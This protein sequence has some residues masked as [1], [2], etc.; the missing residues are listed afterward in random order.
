MDR[1]IV[2][3][4]SLP[5]D[6]D[7]LLPQRFT[8]IAVGMLMRAVMGTGTVI[9][10]LAVTQQASPNMTVQIGQGSLITQTVIDPTGVAFGSLDLDGSTNLVKIATNVAPVNMTA[11]TAPVTSGQSQNW[12]IEAQFLEVDGS[13]TVLP[14][15]NAANPSI[16][17]TGPANAG[18]SQNTLRTNR[19][20]FQWK[21]GAAAATGQ[22][23]TPTPD[24]GWVGIALV[25]VTNGQ[26]SILNSHITGYSAAPYVPTKMPQLRRQ[27][28]QD[29]SIFVSTFG[30]DTNNSGLSASSPFLTLQKAWNY[31]L[32]SLDLN[33]Y[34]V[35]VFV[36]NGTYSGALNASGAVLGLGSGN[37][38]T[39][40]GNTT[41]PSSV[42]LS[43]GSA[44]CITASNNAVVCVAGLSFT[45]SS[46][47]AGALVASNSG[48]IYMTGTC[49]FGACNGPHLWATNSGSAISLLVAYNI[50][51]G[52]VQHMLAQVGGYIT[53]VATLPVTISNTPAF[54]GQFANASLLGLIQFSSLTT[55]LGTGA[56]GARYLAASNGVINTGGQATTYLPGNASGTA[57][58]GQY[59]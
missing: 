13:P 30:N 15:Y 23:S 4:S 36:A 26:T 35:T 37:I 25:T 59:V 43:T 47:G 32:N 20:Q 41:T 1:K 16:P 17:F 6:K 40:I 49:S 19:V 54:S 52:A 28:T 34:N 45:T 46:A 5:Q 31:I 7:I 3:P 57:T 11:L 27:L 12:L 51:G 42:V 9:D 39:F 48:S 10:G 22:Q 55:F 33:G 29:L 44:H 38:I 8:E 2:Y 53:T 21:A 56:T 18:T 24:A 50:T 14:F 58:T